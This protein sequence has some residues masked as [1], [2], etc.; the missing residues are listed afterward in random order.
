[1][2]DSRRRSRRAGSSSSGGGASSASSDSSELLP[3]AVLARIVAIA[4]IRFIWALRCASLISAAVSCSRTSRTS[5]ATAWNVPRVV[6]VTRP[7]WTA[8]STRRAARS[9]AGTGPGLLTP[10]ALALLLWRRTSSAG[11][12]PGS[13]GHVLSSGVRSVRPR[14]AA[15]V[16]GPPQ[17]LHTGLPLPGWTP[18]CSGAPVL[19]HPAA[20]ERRVDDSV[21]RPRIE[22]P[23]R[24]RSDDVAAEGMPILAAT[25]AERRQ[26]GPAT[27]NSTR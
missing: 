26:A 1:M 17:R 7:R 2:P 25:D 14:T 11:T 15:A 3:A 21:Q 13:R 22:V 5:R 24:E 4:L 10:V 19:V 8:A 27:W 12:T 9:S 23:M 20:A 16:P 18:R 6:E